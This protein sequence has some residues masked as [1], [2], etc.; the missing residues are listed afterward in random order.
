MYQRKC[1]ECTHIRVPQIL[2]VDKLHYN[3]VQL[4]SQYDKLHYNIVQLESQYDKLNQNKNCKCFY[5]T[6]RSHDFINVTKSSDREHSNLSEVNKD[7]SKSNTYSNRTNS[8]IWNQSI[9]HQNATMKINSSTNL[10]R[11]MKSMMKSENNSIVNFNKIRYFPRSQRDLQTSTKQNLATIKEEKTDVWD[12][13]NISQI[14]R[15]RRN[16]GKARKERRRPNHSRRKFDPLL[17]TFIGAIPEQ[18]TNDTVKIGPWKKNIRTNNPFDF[19]KFHLADN[20]MSIEVTINGL[21]MISVQIFYYGESKKYSYYVLLN[22]EGGFNTKRLVTCVT[23]ACNVT[24]EITCHTSVITY[25]QKGDRLSVQQKEKDRFINLREG[26][27]H[28]QL[29]MLAKNER[30]TI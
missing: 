19:T 26:F 13:Q 6:I 21:Y 7:N 8:S 1:V 14:K 18:H 12:S 9:D 10:D 5:E 11:I 24:G 20:K 3:I 23:A 27:S 17:A 22:S 4:E 2:H 29:V 15:L 30:K 16:I 28:I 25:L